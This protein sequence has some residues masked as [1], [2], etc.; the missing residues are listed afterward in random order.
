MD[1][2]DTKLV[3]VLSRQEQLITMAL[4]FAVLFGVWVFLFHAG[5]GGLIYSI[6]VVISAVVTAIC[7]V[8]PGNENLSKQE[9]IAKS[10]LVIP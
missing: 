2:A 8:Y 7:T 1:T 4:A 10:G 5:I 3:L 9:K 6:P